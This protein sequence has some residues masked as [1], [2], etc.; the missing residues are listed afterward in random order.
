MAALREIHAHHG[1][2]HIQQRKV[3]GQVGLRTGMRLH[4]GIFGAEQFA[5]TVNGQLLN[6]VHI[7]AA[8]VIAVARIA[9]CILIGEHCA[10]CGH[11][12]G[13]DNVFTCNQL[14]VA[15]LAGQLPVHS[16]SQLFVLSGNTANVVHHILIHGVS[17]PWPVT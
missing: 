17:P 10:H 4:V 1:I 8:A 15:A 3:H 9:L 2:A 6:L 5:G 11:Y 14:N 16:R 7:R 12:R 13:A